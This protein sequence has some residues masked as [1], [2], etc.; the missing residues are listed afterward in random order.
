MI[1]TR[2]ISPFERFGEFIPI[3]DAAL[4]QHIFTAGETISGLAHRYYEDWRKW[5]I[6]ADRNNI[7]DPRQIQP[8]TVLLIPARPV[9]RGFFE[10]Y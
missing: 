8:G 6:I 7:R 2:S 9:E 10:S 5:R 1:T 4:T 3:E